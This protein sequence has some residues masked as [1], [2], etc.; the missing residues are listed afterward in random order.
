MI[1]ADW[2]DFR[3]RL[4]IYS[5]MV[6]TVGESLSLACQALK[7]SGTDCSSKRRKLIATADKIG[8]VASIRRH[9]FLP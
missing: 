5:Q 4:R 1:S 3:T 2:E 6:M 9:S 7:G 8:S